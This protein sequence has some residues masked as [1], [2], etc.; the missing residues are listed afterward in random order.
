MAA[1]F[2]RTDHEALSIFVKTAALA[3]VVHNL[4]QET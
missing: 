2:H 4:A 1:W 3:Y